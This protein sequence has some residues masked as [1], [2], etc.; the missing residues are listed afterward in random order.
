[1]RIMIYFPIIGG[2]AGVAY[3]TENIINNILR[4]TDTEILLV[5]NQNGKNDF[6]FVESENLKILVVNVEKSIQNIIFQ[7]FRLNKIAAK[8]NID[9][10]F[11]PANPL[12]L[13]KLKK[14]KYIST[15]HD[16]NELDNKNKYEFLKSFYR[17]NIMLPLGIRNSDVIVTVSDFSLKQF[18]K[19]YPQYV[20]KCNVIYNGIR[21]FK[22]KAIPKEKIILFTG[23]IDPDGKNLYKMLN[24]FDKINE[25]DK[26]YRL[27]LAGSLF[28][29]GKEFKEFTEKKYGNRVRFLGFIDDDQLEELFNKARYTVL[30]SRLEGFGLPVFESMKCGTPVIIN[31]VCEVLNNLVGDLAISVDESNYDGFSK[32]IEMEKSKELYYD[33]C[34]KSIV[35]SEK[36][37]WKEAALKLIQLM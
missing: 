25:V 26:E 8:N 36:F 16:L 19:Y 22:H 3:Y 5:T 10:I 35:F 34:N 30:F 7:M 20:H 11:Y 28:D 2:K 9:K 27:I 13:F 32:F 18:R 4:Y 14:T 6:K 15:I 37:T 12:I 17:R 29:G 24:L 31:R 23:R 33:I 21:D 1:M